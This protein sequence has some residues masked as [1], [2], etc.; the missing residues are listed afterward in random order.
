MLAPQ[1]RNRTN[2]N[3]FN[4]EPLIN[5]R[6]FYNWVDYQPPYLIEWRRVRRHVLDHVVEGDQQAD[7]REAR[8]RRRVVRPDRREPEQRQRHAHVEVVRPNTSKLISR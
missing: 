3:A 4:V 1:L 2:R 8:A 7:E 5:S 6:I